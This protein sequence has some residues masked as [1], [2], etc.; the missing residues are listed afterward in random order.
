MAGEAKHPCPL[1]KRPVGGVH[2]DSCPRSSH[3]Q[4][5]AQAYA[6]WL[7]RRKKVN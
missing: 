6:S 5:Q 2:R 4:R 3:V 1:C 7:H